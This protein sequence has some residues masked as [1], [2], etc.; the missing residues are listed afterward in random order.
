LNSWFVFRSCRR[1]TI[2]TDEP[3]SSVSATTLALER[4]RPAPP[5]RQ[6]PASLSVH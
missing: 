6:T 2:D 1:A 3:G 4:L 5:L